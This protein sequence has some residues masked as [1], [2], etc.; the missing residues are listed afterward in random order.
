MSTNKE[1]NNE[2]N[3]DSKDQEIFCEG[4]NC[5]VPMLASPKTFCLSKKDIRKFEHNIESVLR[6]F[7][8]E[9][10]KPIPKHYLMGTRVA[11]NHMRNMKKQKYLLVA[12]IR[13]HNQVAWLKP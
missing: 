10:S 11:Y 12:S 4:E 13:A 2:E 8:G 5:H 3:K 9:L 7:V 1:K 6:C